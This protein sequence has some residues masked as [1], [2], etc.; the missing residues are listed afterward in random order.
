VPIIAGE[1]CKGEPNPG[2]RRPLAQTL[3]RHTEIDPNL[4]RVVEAV[5]DLPDAIRRTV[6]ALIDAI[7]QR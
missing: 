2:A 6:L 4:V 3:A 5:P 7:A 1:F